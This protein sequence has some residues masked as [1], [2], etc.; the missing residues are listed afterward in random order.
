MKN[1]Q[2]QRYLAIALF[3]LTVAA[4]TGALLRFGLIWGMP[5]WATS[6]T[7]I[8][9]AHSHLM[10]FGWVSLA[11]MALIWHFLPNET[12]RPL[13]RGINIQMAASALLALLSFP[14]FWINGYGTTEIGSANL[15]LGSMAAGI[16]GLLWLFFAGLY[17]RATWQL[18]ERTLAIQL[19]DWA[20]L[21]LLLAF[22][23]ALG[24]VAAVIFAISEPLVQ[25]L[26]LHLFLDL[27]GLGWFQLGLLG[28]LWAWLRQRAISAP[29]WLPSQS[30]ALLLVP[31]FL[32]GVSPMVLSNELFWVGALSNVGAAFLLI[33][34]L[35]GLW[36]VR[37][38]LSIFVILALL[39][40]LVHIGTAFVTL[41]PGVWRWSAG[42]QLRIFF[43]HNFLLGWISSALI[44]L[45]L[46]LLAQRKSTQ[47]PLLTILWFCGIGTM[48]VA[49]LGIGMIQ[50]IPLSAALLFRI[51]AWS[52]LPI[53]L[54]AAWLLIHSGINQKS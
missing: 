28:A 18:A 50:W 25:Q 30:L 11:L 31:T 43:L 4:S 36:K 44:G 39:P 26:S 7:A 9:H 47:P 5:G 16:N 6:Y 19:W 37:A 40:L 27:F 51:A 45:I 10:Y 8:R 53:V 33:W 1:S 17:L 14:A 22:G 3:A 38:Q 41:W 13:P 48:I 21:L 46:V 2:T 12:G 23:G 34:H 35:H 49:L 15:P 29:H 54:A 32:L 52:T 24:L 20:V 42:T